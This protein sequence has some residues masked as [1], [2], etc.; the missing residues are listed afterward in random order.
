M[1][2]RPATPALIAGLSTVLSLDF[3]MML[4]VWDHPLPFH[5]PRTLFYQIYAWPVFSSGVTY[6]EAAFLYAE[7]GSHT[8]DL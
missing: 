6:V 4:L 2:L 8:K 3:S 5:L 1:S 7:M